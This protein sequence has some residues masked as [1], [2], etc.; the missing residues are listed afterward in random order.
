MSSPGLEVMVVEDEDLQRQLICDRLVAAGF[1]VREAADGE[2]AV[3]AFEERPP[4]LVLMDVRLPGMDGLEATKRIKSMPVDRYV[5]VIACTALDDL[6]NKQAAFDFGVDDYLT[7]PFDMAELVLRIRSATRMIATLQRWKKAETRSTQLQSLVTDVSKNLKRPL[8]AEHIVGDSPSLEKV[9]AQI[10]PAAASEVTVLL[11]GETGTGKEMFARLLHE[12]SPRRD[13]K[14]RVQD[15]SSLPQHLL[16]SE[17]FGHKKGAFT[18]AHSDRAGLFVEAEGGTVFLDEIGDM[19]LAAQA[20]LL[21]LLQERE[22]K[23]V[24]ADVP[25]KVDVRIIA[26]THRDLEKLVEQG[27]FRRDLYYRLGQVRIAL[28]PLRQRE[29]DISR[30][31]EHFRRQYAQRYEKT[32]G[33]WT[34]EALAVLSAYPF[35]GNVRQLKNEVERVVLYYGDAPHLLPEHISDEIRAVVEGRRTPMNGSA[36]PTDGDAA[37]T[38]DDATPLQNAVETAERRAI[39]ETLQRCNYHITKTAGELGLT[40]QGLWKK[41]KRLGIR[42]RR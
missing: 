6:R 37:A 12:N 28:P 2:S 33:E 16:E 38:N 36:A 29:G 10:A 23:P 19:P 41:M 17:L 35:P 32:P 30:L 20:R 40:R 4:D 8:G 9:F 31:A 26:A 13:H 3:A 34:P 18:G 21:R 1:R 39:V 15:C 14:F 7:K 25:R 27:R 24:G 22:V 5:P 11:F 42:G